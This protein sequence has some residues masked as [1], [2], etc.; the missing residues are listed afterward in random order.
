[1]I[2]IIIIIIITTTTI[3]NENNSNYRL[4]VYNAFPW[5]FMLNTLWILE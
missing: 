2:I 5:H 3:I 4:H 1:M